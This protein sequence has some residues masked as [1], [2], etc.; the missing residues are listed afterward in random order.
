MHVDFLHRAVVGAGIFVDDGLLGAA[1]VA[2]GCGGGRG[3]AGAEGA[4]CLG[5]CT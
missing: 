3:P 1:G 2:G 5:L 4:D